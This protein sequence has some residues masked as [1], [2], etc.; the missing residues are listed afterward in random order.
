M[1]WIVELSKVYDNIQ[2]NN[3]IIDKPIPI[4]HVTNN[5]SVTI[6]LNKN[7]QILK[8][9]LVDKKDPERSTCMPCTESCA[10]RTSGIDAYPL[11]DKLE[12][13]SGNSEKHEKYSQ[14]LK[15]WC[16]SPW[17][18]QKIK[19]VY[20][21][22]SENT[23]LEDLRK[24]G[25]KKEEIQDFVRWQVEIPDDAIPELW[26]DRNIYD[27]WIQYY[28]SSYYDLYCEENFI[29]KDEKEKRIRKSDL[30]YTD[31]KVSKIAV[32]HPSKIRNN[33]D[34]AKLISS[35]DTENFTFRG[36]FINN[37]EACQIGSEATQKAHSALRWLINR[38]GVALGDGLSIVT[39]NEAGDRIPSVTDS[40]H[41][42]EEFDYGLNFGEKNEEYSTASEFAKAINNKLSGYYQRTGSPEKIM[43]MAIKEA[44]PGQGRASIALYRELINSDMMTALNNWYT[45][46]LWYNTY[47]TKS[48][49]QESKT[50]PVDS[51]G[52]PSPKDIAKCAYG[53]QV[54]PTLV[55]KTVQRILPCILDGNPIPS[56]LEIQCIRSAS[57][58]YIFNSKFD[59]SYVLQT[60]CAVYKY[61][62]IV[63]N[64]EVYDLSL[65]ENRRSRDYLYGRLLAVAHQE[66]SAALAKMGDNRN[67]NAMRY[68]QQF[69]IRPASTWKIIYE[70]LIPYKRHLA[71]GLAAWFENKIRDITDLFEPDDYL[72]D[73]PLS[74][75]YLLGYQCQLKSKGSTQNSES[76]PE[77]NTLLILEE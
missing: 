8:A 7:G 37:G 19:A 49:S 34:K 52:T 66:E 53:S 2:R 51:I 61:N 41:E 50:L 12:Y 21:Y 10:A 31:G 36:R 11:S 18:T 77:N 5:A 74:G 45:R 3:N 65:E 68:M 54:K 13:V 9:N 44:T 16:E 57:N 75:E 64:K 6:T 25:I 62:Q 69:S 15:S 22:I 4:Y 24:Y 17:G 23:L 29:K 30:S 26:K 35:N 32:F 60:A 27:S 63:K 42:L 59:K 39:W 72:N 58:L 76:D 48:K 33:G 28:N 46:L 71:P 43:I 1:S 73:K 40:S 47:Y 38:Q 14:L 67:T 55:E 70:K 56:D 20:K